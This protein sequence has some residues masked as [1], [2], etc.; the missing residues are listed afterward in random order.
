MRILT[1]L[2]FA[3]LS[4]LTLVAKTGDVPK[5]KLEAFRT[6][7]EPVLKRVCF[8]C[9][10]PEKQKGKLR[11]DVLDPDL[12][13][14]KDVSWWLEVF[15]VISNGEMPPED[16]KVQLT[17]AEKARIVD[18]VSGEILVA[19]QVRRSEQGHTSFRRM[20]RYEYKHALQDL[21]GLPHDFSRDLPPETVSEDG[22]K[23][24]SELL[25]MTVVQFDQYRELARKALERVTV[26]GERPKPVYYG[27]TM[28]AASAQ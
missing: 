28:K 5:A 20:T 19:S 14:G 9:H 16:A 1:T 11:I 7:V 21:L 4:N 6:R 3:F 22:F 8:G 23:N 17:D 24:S 15:D 26:R 18:W 27:I 2:L 12:L 13:K 10:G 25:H